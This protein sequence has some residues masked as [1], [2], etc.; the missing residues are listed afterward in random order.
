MRL[1][2]LPLLSVGIALAA[3]ATARRPV[4]STVARELPLPPAVAAAVLGG[5]LRIELPFADPVPAAAG[6]ALQRLGEHQYRIAF[7]RR[8]N[9][10]APRATHR[11]ALV[12]ATDPAAG[13]DVVC[14]ALPPAQ[15][16]DRWPAVAGFVLDV[17]GAGS[18]CTVTGH[19]PGELVPAIE[20]A[21]LLAV[22]P[23]TPTPGL[24]ERN[25]ATW[26]QHRLL[27]AAGG[28]ERA[29]DDVTAFAR[30]QAALRL[31]AV[32]DA[33]HGA[34]AADAERRGQWTRAL[35]HD[36]QALLGAGDPRRRHAAAARVVGHARRGDDAFAWRAAARAQLHGVDPER[37]A[38]LLHTARR[39]HVEP[40]FD[41]RLQ[42]QL[43]HLADALD[44][45]RASA[46]LAREHAGL[47]VDA[48]VYAGELWSHG[49]QPVP[50]TTRTLPAAPAR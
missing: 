41:Y 11:L 37:G 30:R 2:P 7:T 12:P 9:G 47:D 8:D 13:V 25:L 24:E 1:L 6:V 16:T 18:G 21:L 31:G 34:L 4:T 10:W 49:P 26:A 42:S 5:A 48:V 43:H 36:W 38:A 20:R 28:A 29:G 27:A 23:A 44:A 45:A 3:C 40:A 32:P 33:V 14:T 15:C 46:L 19:A 39:L 50:A 22:D 17:R 35:D